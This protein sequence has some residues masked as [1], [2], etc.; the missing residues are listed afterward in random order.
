M[1]TLMHVQKCTLFSIQECLLDTKQQLMVAKQTNNSVLIFVQT[2]IKI[3]FQW[4]ELNTSASNS[5]NPIDFQMTRNISFRML[6][7]R[8]F[9]KQFSIIKIVPMHF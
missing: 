6:C 3:H 9:R 5:W 7:I 2:Q 1:Q 8:Y 4:T